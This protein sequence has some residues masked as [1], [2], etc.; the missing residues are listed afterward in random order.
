MWALQE[1]CHMLC[2]LAVK[3]GIKDYTRLATDPA[4]K[5]PVIF[6]LDHTSAWTDG[7]TGW[8]LDQAA[9]GVVEGAVWQLHQA[10][11]RTHFERPPSEATRSEPGAGVAEAAGLLAC[12]YHIGC[13]SAR[14]VPTA[15]ST[16]AAA[17]A[18][19]SA[20]ARQLGMQ[21][22]DAATEAVP[23]LVR[24]ALADD[25]AHEGGATITD[26]DRLG[27]TTALWTL[28][29]MHVD[30]CAA[31]LTALGSRVGAASA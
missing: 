8:S 26:R 22:L 18:L 9:A 24:L 25:Q 7:C 5:R 15:S 10:G 12:L 3:A 27:A 17:S 4:A 1:V 13:N 11:A 2:A 30:V 16:V 31:I 20:A 14:S 21:L 6:G 23:E 28:A 29:H 19:P